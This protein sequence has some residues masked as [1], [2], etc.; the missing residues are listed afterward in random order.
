MAALVT[1]EV[2]T[3][4][5]L[6][7]K[8]VTH[9]TKM[10]QG[11]AEPNEIVFMASLH[12]GFLDTPSAKCGRVSIAELAGAQRDDSAHE[13]IVACRVAG[14]RSAPEP[15]PETGPAQA[16]PDSH[17]PCPGRDTAG[18]EG[19]ACSGGPGDFVC[20]ARE[21]FSHAQSLLP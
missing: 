3:M 10:E 4:G 19:P 6:A 13:L 17:V 12:D 14:G 16:T 1:L 9:D 18:P 8:Q 5:R 7:A 15:T 21:R 2:Q 11:V 20:G